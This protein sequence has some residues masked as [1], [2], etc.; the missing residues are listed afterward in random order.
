MLNTLQGHEGKVAGVDFM[1]SND[2]VNEQSLFSVVT[3]GFDK[4]IKIWS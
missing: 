4:T 2:A 3:C 1:S